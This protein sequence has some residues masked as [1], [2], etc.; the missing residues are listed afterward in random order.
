MRLVTN[1]PLI[2]RNA[3]IGKASSIAGLAVLLGGLVYSFK[4]PEQSYVPFITLLI[5]FLFS[6]V[7]IYFANRW[8]KPPR[9]DQA[10]DAALKGLDDR[11]ALYHYRLGGSHALICPAGVFALATKS[12]PGAIRFAN[13]RWAQTGGGSF[14]LKLFGQ[15]GLGNPSVEAASEAKRVH[16][17][18]AKALPGETLPSVNPVIV[19]THPAAVVE[20]DDAPFPAMH[21]K[22]LKGYIRG[23]P[24]GP[25][26]SKAHLAQVDARLG[27]A[28]SNDTAAANT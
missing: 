27:L 25:A 16:E 17:W 24:K 10:L 14:F 22:K 15:E 2:K 21:A 1:E 23:L 18:L 28:E 13:G 7:G 11:Y 9:P 26:L 8:V 3:F 5:G 12:Q 6:N 20:A 19:F 4:F